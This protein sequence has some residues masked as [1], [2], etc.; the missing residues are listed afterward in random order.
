MQHLRH[1]QRSL[2]SITAAVLFFSPMAFATDQATVAF[3]T[4]V[5]HDG[6]DRQSPEE[7]KMARDQIKSEFADVVEPREVS[8]FQATAI[9]KNYDYLDP[10]HE[11][12]SDLLRTAV[13]YF[14]ANK[15]KFKNQNYLTVVDFAPRS[16]HYRFFLVNLKNGAVEKFHTTHGAGSVTDD[17]GYARSFGNVIDSGKSSL[18]FVR[19]AEVY[20]GTYH[21]SLRLDGLSTTNSNIRERA[22]VFHGW[23]GVKEEN[24]LQGLTLGC[25]ALDWAVKD[26]VLD[27]IKEGSLMYVGVS[28]RGRDQ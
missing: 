18:G 22:I 15:A 12:P 9:L 4:V 21:R 7:V 3:A 23:D 19:T 17:E 26:E 1:L 6:F 8:A 10:N 16:D 5:S 13:L 28:Q 20:V 24:V 14:D 27:K 25:I 11:V 2:V